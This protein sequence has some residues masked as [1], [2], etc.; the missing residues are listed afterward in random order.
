MGLQKFR[1]DIMGE[2][3]ANGAI[4]CYAQWMG[5]PSLSLIRNC[6]CKVQGKDLNP[7]T[8]YITGEADTVFSIPAVCQV[9]GKRIVGWVGQEDGKYY[10]RAN[11]DQR[12]G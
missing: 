9:Q 5:G 2:Q 1:A 11:A 6:P 3:D 4:P 10:F 7:R 8:V 12:V